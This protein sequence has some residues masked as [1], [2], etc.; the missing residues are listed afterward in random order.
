MLFPEKREFFMEG[1]QFFTFGF[2]GTG[3]NADLPTIAATDFS[4]VRVQREILRRSRIGVIGTRRA[5]SSSG[6]G[7]HNYAYGADAVFQFFENISFT[8]Y[9]R[10]R[11]QRGCSLPR[12]R[13][14]ILGYSLRIVATARPGRSVRPTREK[15]NNF[16]ESTSKLMSVN[17]F[18]GA[19]MFS[20]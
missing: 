12:Q 5:P 19:L 18:L 4:V 2:Q 11:R 10:R 20:K 14:S 15:T 8:E 3:F 1:P 16:A 9:N 7:T 6:A 13:R 17:C